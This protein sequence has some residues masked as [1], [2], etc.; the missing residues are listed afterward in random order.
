MDRARIHTSGR[1]RLTHMF[2][3]PCE[4]KGIPTRAKVAA[5]NRSGVNNRK[6]LKRLTRTNG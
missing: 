2:P 6:S 1:D 4:E 3:S 5:Y